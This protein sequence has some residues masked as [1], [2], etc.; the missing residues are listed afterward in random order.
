[1]WETILIGILSSIVIG[2]LGWGAT[3]LNRRVGEAIDRRR[4]YLWLQSNTHDEPGKSHVDTITLAKGTRLSEERVRKACMSD[5]RIYRSSGEPERWSTWR[6]E[7]QSIYETR[8]I[9]SL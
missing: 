2:L 7:P 5:Q 1:M 8:G 9:I 6:Q 4:V 3:F